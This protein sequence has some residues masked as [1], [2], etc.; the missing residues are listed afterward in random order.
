[1]PVKLV[2]IHLWGAMNTP[3]LGGNKQTPR[4]IGQPGTT[5]R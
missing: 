5:G 3:H 1:M 2:T 4:E